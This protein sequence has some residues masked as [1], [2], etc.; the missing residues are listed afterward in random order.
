MLILTHFRVTNGP[1]SAEGVGVITR[2]LAVGAVVFISVVYISAQAPPS[3]P[4][5]AP[6]AVAA[7]PQPATT[8]PATVETKAAA[9]DATAP[10]KVMDQY[11]V[12]CHNAKQKTAN[13][14]LDQL[15]LTHLGEHP[16]IGEKVVRKLRAGLMPPTGMPRPDR[17]T[18][19]SMVEWMETE[20][21]RNAET[22]LPAPG[23]HRMN[24]TEYTNAIRDLLALEV[25]ATKFLPVDDS[26][27]GFD[28]QAAA[29]TISP[30]A[31]SAALRLATS[32]RQLSGYGTSRP[33]RH[34]T[35]T[36]K[37]C[38]SAR[39]AASSSIISSPQT[40]TTRST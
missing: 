21:D 2:L 33:T 6:R 1:R 13:L 19:D 15:D 8:K 27:R 14:L 12:T 5:A 29:L 32:T 18:L 31:R 39:A 16:E 36:S 40:A 37:D 10:R 3:R 35:T 4:A 26:T 34:R 38:R 24:R 20:L 30:P 23:L 9:A 28:N 25:D 11:C 7:V 17:A 22:H